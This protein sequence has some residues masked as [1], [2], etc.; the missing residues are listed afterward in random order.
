MIATIRH[1]CIRCTLWYC[2]AKNVLKFHIIFDCLVLWYQF[3]TC[4][5][6]HY[7]FSK[8][9]M[10]HKNCLSLIYKTTL[11]Q[12]QWENGHILAVRTRPTI[13]AV[14]HNL[15]DSHCSY[16]RN[17]SNVNIRPAYRL[18]QGMSTQRQCRPQCPAAAHAQCSV[19]NVLCRLSQY[20][21]W[22]KIQERCA[23]A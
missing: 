7:F 20:T 18:Y 9:N 3:L 17:D 12:K 10:M 14:R 23:I 2:K 11:A 6:L 13:V 16:S 1:H 19:F 5:V 22:L 15:F 21:R 8:Q 4:Y